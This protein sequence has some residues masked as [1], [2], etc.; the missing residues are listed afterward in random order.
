MF[1]SEKQ[2]IRVLF[3]VF[4][5]LTI[6]AALVVFGRYYNTT[7]R[8]F[9]PNVPEAPF[10]LGLDLL[11]GTHLVYDADVSS[12]SSEE[13]GTAVE[14]V[15]DVIERR[16]NVFGVAEP[17]VQTAK[18][19]DDYR[20][21]VELAGIQDINQAIKMIGETPLLEFKEENTAPK[22][23]TAEQEKQLTD[24]NQEAEKRAQSVLGKALSGGD[25]AA[26][27][28]EYSE[29]DTTKDGGG[30]LGWINKAG[31]FDKI[32]AQAEAT[33]IATTPF[34]LVDEDD[35]FNIIKIFAKRAQ[36]EGDVGLDKKE[37]K[38]SHI[39]ICFQ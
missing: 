38:A 19:G 25:F 13:R 9:L 32:F 11:G 8:K 24:Y 27:A 20:L 31:N 1:K 28:R 6:A 15:R 2:K 39:L 21:V 23:L 37:I 34:S 18:S 5:V 22:T 17:V 33:D 7:L 3:A 30:D 36:K 14:G 16:V 10:R 4:V 12:V 35:G 29:D 26:L